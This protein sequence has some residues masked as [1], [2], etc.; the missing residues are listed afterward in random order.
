LQQTCSSDS[1]SVQAVSS[2][3]YSGGALAVR[4][5]EKEPGGPAGKKR[6]TPNPI[7]FY[8]ATMLGLAA[9]VAAKLK[10]CRVD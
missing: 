5:W 7:L 1:L 3:N 6:E 2:L 8:P 4:R 10:L 9:A